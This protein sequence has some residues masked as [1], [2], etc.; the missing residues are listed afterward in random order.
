LSGVNLILLAR[1]RL[2]EMGLADA[3]RLGVKPLHSTD[4]RL[5]NRT[6][7]RFAQF[8]RIAAA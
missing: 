2:P 8:Y 4:Q 6:Q 3:R 5:E 7:V 1:Q